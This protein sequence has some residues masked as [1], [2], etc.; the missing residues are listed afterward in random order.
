MTKEET[1]CFPQQMYFHRKEPSGAVINHT[2]WFQDS[3][4]KL[5]FVVLLNKI[6]IESCWAFV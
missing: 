4:K 6:L 3:E 5:L 2:I 1:L